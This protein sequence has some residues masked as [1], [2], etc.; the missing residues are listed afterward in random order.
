M[1]KSTEDRLGYYYQDSKDKLYGPFKTL[2][3]CEFFDYKYIWNLVKISDDSNKINKITVDFSSNTL[4]IE[5]NENAS[6]K[7]LD[8]DIG[9][10]VHSFLPEQWEM[11]LSK[12]YESTKN[13]TIIGKPQIEGECLDEVLYM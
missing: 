6:I 8:K 12:V 2:K 1:A 5:G 13:I 7:I 4:T 10:G 9:V 11:L 3:E